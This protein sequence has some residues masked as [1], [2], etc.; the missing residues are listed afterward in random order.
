MAA[1]FI[2]SCSQNVYVNVTWLCPFIKLSK[3]LLHGIG[4]REKTCFS[5][6]HVYLFVTWYSTKTCSTSIT[7]HRPGP[8]VPAVLQHYIPCSRYRVLYL[9]ST[10]ALVVFA[11]GIWRCDLVWWCLLYS[12]LICIIICISNSNPR[13]S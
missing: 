5:H 1:S 12:L 6:Q 2:S 10:R 13:E 8:G 9:Y 3:C 4:I 11:F 7:P